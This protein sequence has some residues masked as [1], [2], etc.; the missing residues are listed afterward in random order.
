[1]VGGGHI[2]VSDIQHVQV[3][4]DNA[5][6]LYNITVTNAG[7]MALDANNELY[8]ANQS[9]GT[10]EGY[11]LGPSSAT[12]D[13]TWS[14]QG[15]LTAPTGVAI[16]ANGNLLVSDATNG[17]I[18]NLSWTDDSILNQTSGAPANFE[19]YGVMVTP[20]GTI[21]G[22][23]FHN[24][25]VVL[26]NADYT[27][28]SAITGSTWALPL[29]G[30]DCTVMD[31]QGN[32]FI[33]DPGNDRVVYATVQGTYLG[34]MDGFGFAWNLALDSADDLFVTDGSFDDVK[35]YTR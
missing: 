5:D 32:L 9:G 11:T 12:Y 1:M 27:Y 7:A 4:D 21:Y 16:D 20:A 14:G 28:N 34:E 15:T 33:A 35:E 6:Y 24:P 3:F 17:A 25:E 8:V 31:S 10:V 29:G 19:P 30:T 26:F 23:D 22:S 13:Y 2:I 18:Y